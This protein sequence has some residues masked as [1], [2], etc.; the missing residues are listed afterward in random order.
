MAVPT[1]SLQRLISQNEEERE[2]LHLAC[3]SSG[4]F[5]LNLC[6]H[7]NDTRGSQSL[8]QAQQIFQLARRFFDFD[9]QYKL[10]YE[11]D[12]WG[13]LQIGGYK[14][15]GKHSGV[16]SGKRDGFENFLVPLNRL[17]GF[18][19]G[20]VPGP[21]P[22]VFES[23]I[24]SLAEFQK[25]CHEICNV[26][27]SSLSIAGHFDYD[28]RLQDSHK[29][30]DPSTTSLAMLKYL[31][32]EALSTDQIG[33]MAH[34]DVGSLTLVFTTSPGLEI[35]HHE[36]SSWVPV[37]PSPGTVAVNVGDAL[38]FLSGG[39]LASCI[40]RVVPQVDKETGLSATRFSLAFFQ[41]PGL[42]AT[43][44]DESG[45][46]WTGEQWHKKKYRI[47]RA[48]NE[49]QLQSSLLTG[50]VGFLGEL[51]GKGGEQIST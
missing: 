42:R 16:V 5:L 21:L 9:D 19:D 38:R 18:K 44:E 25:N 14:A 22:P 39:S 26:I 35:F 1:I 27:L 8:V 12:S 29:I 33:H 3:K 31:P 36:T 41:R 6:D 50:K 23:E 17:I 15:A 32:G 24:G 13:E 4:V 10:G 28:Q 37:T 30:E 48:T 51:K 2:R 47:F 11:M 45:Q 7:G 49:E 40:H 20:V 34:T 43:F 46:D